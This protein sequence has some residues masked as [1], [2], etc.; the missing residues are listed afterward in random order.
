M[1]IKRIRVIIPLSIILLAIIGVVLWYFAYVL[2]KNEVSDSENSTTSSTSG[3]GTNKQDTSKLS[4]FI[5]L[6]GDAFDQ[7]YL[8]DMMAHHEGGINMAEQAQSVVPHEELRTLA[9]NIT[10]TQSQE[11]VKMQQWQKDWDYKATM[12]SGH[13]SHGGMAMGMSGDMV[14]MMG[15]LKD[16]TGKAYEKVFLAQMIVH[17]KQAIDMSQYAE[18]NAKH[19]EIKSFAKDLIVSQGAEIRQM[20]QWQTSWGY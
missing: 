2:N 17:H 19:Q 20:E 12:G 3:S 8:A 6:K 4:K 9:G 1:H 14:E 5:S 7:A 16:L 10:L 13:M 18:V 11:L 15:K